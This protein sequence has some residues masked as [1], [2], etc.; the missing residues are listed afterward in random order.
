MVSDPEMVC[1]SPNVSD[2]R[3][4]RSVVSWDSVFGERV[5]ARVASFLGV[6][7][8]RKLKVGYWVEVRS[9]EELLKTLDASGQLDGISFMRRYSHCSA[10]T[11]FGRLGRVTI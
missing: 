11:I 2:L 5:H 4:Q 8:T 6:S 1:E 10:S 9:K 7:R 3:S